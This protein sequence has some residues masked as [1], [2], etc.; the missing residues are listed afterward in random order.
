MKISYMLL[1]LMRLNCA[2]CVYLMWC[3]NKDKFYAVY[4]S[5]FNIKFSLLFW[6]MSMADIFALR[7][8]ILWNSQNILS[9]A[10]SSSSLSLSL[11][12]TIILPNAACSRID[13]E[14]L[15]F[16]KFLIKNSKIF[17]LNADGG[18]QVLSSSV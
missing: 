7:W 17:T 8:W 18:N 10:S 4:D 11:A 15:P 2:L 12:T 1:G 16:L 14:I 3:V 9:C 6:I 13:E 5:I